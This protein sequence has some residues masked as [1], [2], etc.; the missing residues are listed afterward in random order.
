M[1]AR[2]A[3]SAFLMAACATLAAL[4]SPARAADPSES[5][6][7][8]AKRDLHDRFYGSTILVARPIGGD[9]HVGFIVNKP[10]RMTLGKLFPRHEPSR[11]VADP[12][13][14]GGPVS[15]E[16]IFALVEGRQN[17][18]GRSIR[19]LEDLYLAVDS[20]VV[21]RVIEKQSSQARFLAGMVM[22]RPG[23]LNEELRRGLW[24]VQDANTDVILHKPTET[25]WEELVARS[26]RKANAI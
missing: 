18:G 23:E 25:M 16:V 9:R 15:P 20:D 4:G 19:I 12:V 24:Y 11:K 2:S 26:E 7:L 21:D 13:F 5:I 14:L 6:L 17:P 10:T 8:V 3:L 1:T 22:W